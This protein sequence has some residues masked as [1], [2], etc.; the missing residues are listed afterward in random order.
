[1]LKTLQA[2]TP[3]DGRSI[4]I[5]NTSLWVV[6]GRPLY[7]L[8]VPLGNDAAFET[9][10]STSLSLTRPAAGQYHDADAFRLCGL[11][12]EQFFLMGLKAETP[13]ERAL[14]SRLQDAAYVTDQSDSWVML[15][16]N[17]ENALRAMERISPIDLSPSTFPTG[18]IARTSMEHLSA[19]VM[20]EDDATLTLLSPISSAESFWHAVE[21]SLTNV[22]H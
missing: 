21:Q 8:S 13:D 2:S 4:T 5:D 1:M 12:Q 9:A 16:I 6:S 11:A 17:G 20:A 10:L 18:S 14:K 19:I 15:Q 22:S 3:L 7:S